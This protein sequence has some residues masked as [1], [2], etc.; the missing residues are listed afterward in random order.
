MLTEKTNLPQFE[1][2]R[3]SD[4][5]ILWTGK[6]AL[7]PF[8]LSGIPFL[9]IGLIW[10]I[11]DL[12]FFGVFS[13]NQL[14][15]EMSTF[16]TVFFIIHLFPCWGSIL[17]LLR[18]FLVHN[19]TYYA[20]TNKRLMMRSGFWGTDF[21]A[22]DYDKIADLTVTVNSIENIFKVGTI[23]A[24]TGNMTA[25][26]MRIYDR[27]LAISNPYEV[28][29]KIKELAVD[30]KTDWNY[31]NALRPETNPGYRTKYDPHGKNY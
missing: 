31:P 16:I 5:E 7:I 26:G 17:N 4:E 15:G 8:I 6:P 10:G 23:S 30:V 29:K 11:L 21:K 28:F 18:L 3:D 2:V 14:M 25:K 27:F 13:K 12:G 9:I 22:I 20:F 19:N 1:A 24:F